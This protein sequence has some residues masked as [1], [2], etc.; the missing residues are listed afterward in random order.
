MRLAV[1]DLITRTR[2]VQV[3]EKCPKCGADLMEEGSLKVWEYQDQHRVAHLMPLDEHSIEFEDCQPQQGESWLMQSYQCSK[4]DYTLVDARSEQL[5]SES[6]GDEMEDFY[7]HKGNYRRMEAAKK[8]AE[9]LL[10]KRAGSEEEAYE[11]EP[12]DHIEVLR[13]HL[14]GGYQ[15]TIELVEDLCKKLLE[16]TDGP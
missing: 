10:G 13:H 16:K 4:C 5:C 12:T 8:L 3:P 11:E 14:I 6:L 15:H 7:V 1:D 9:E 2:A